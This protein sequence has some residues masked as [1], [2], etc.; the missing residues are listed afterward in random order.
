MT[1]DCQ[2]EYNW[3]KVIGQAYWT[4]IK[5]ILTI[6]RQY[7]SVWD[8]KEERL[9][10]EILVRSFRTR[11]LHVKVIYTLKRTFSFVGEVLG[12]LKHCM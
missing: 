8:L 7:N 2:T 12:N 10:S 6:I 11:C 9:E 3:Y 4:K 5:A 1:F